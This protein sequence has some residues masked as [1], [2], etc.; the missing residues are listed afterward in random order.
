MKTTE[1]TAG[2]LLAHARRAL[3]VAAETLWPTRCACCDA[4]GELL[5]DDCLRALPY[6]DSCLACPTCGAAFGRVQCS[7]CNTVMMA[8]CGRREL[9]FDRMA[10]AVTLDEGARRIVT[11][12]KDAGERRLA[13][14]IASIMARYVAPSWTFDAITFVP[15]TS[16]ALRRRGFDHTELL[17]QALAAHIGTSCQS[18]LARPQAFDQR[19]L[20]RNERIANM[21]MRFRC[22]DVEVPASLIVIDDVCTTG[23]TL[24]AAADA[25]RASGAKTLYGLTFARA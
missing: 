8:A 9:P 4:P 25:L 12:Y 5:C 11:T 14:T 19:R 3:D 24:Y 15:A 2:S 22:A 18:L 10:S 16:S 21:S 13:E 23:A 6:I 7:E 17:A 20:S 1:T